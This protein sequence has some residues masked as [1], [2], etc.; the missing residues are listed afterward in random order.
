M[1][2][3][4][5]ALGDLIELSRAVGSDPMIVQ[6]GGGNTSVKD[7]FGTRMAITASGALLADVA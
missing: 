5:K 6:V 1:T 7:S 4:A 3:N 2:V